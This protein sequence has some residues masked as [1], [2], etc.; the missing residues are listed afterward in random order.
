MMNSWRNH[1]AECHGV[2]CRKEQRL[3]GANAS[4]KGGFCTDATQ[5]SPILWVKVGVAKKFDNNWEDAAWMLYFGVPLGTPRST[6]SIS[7][8]RVAC[9]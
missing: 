5:C 6:S 7:W 9:S 3:S 2:L 4:G 1:G 8:D